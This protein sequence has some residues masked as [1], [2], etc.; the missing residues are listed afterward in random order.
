MTTKFEHNWRLRRPDRRI[1]SPGE[2]ELATFPSSR[3]TSPVV[4]VPDKAT[5][6]S[7]AYASSPR[8]LV[9]SLYWFKGVAYFMQEQY[10]QAIEWL[11]R[12][13]A[14]VPDLFFPIVDLA[15]ALVIRGHPA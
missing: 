1:S 3:P 7:I 5:R 6:S 13:M 2:L 4:L 14:A 11:R 10:E 12:S 9:R 15:P 8:R